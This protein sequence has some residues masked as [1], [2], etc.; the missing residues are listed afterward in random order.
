MD[1]LADDNFHR[2]IINAIMTKIITS[3]LSLSVENYFVFC[4]F[5]NKVF[6]SIE[7][8]LYLNLIVDEQ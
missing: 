3:I 2:L 7:N 5:L 8:Y 1:S 4:A 6:H